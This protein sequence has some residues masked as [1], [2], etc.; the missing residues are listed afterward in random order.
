VA[1]QGL[2][3]GHD[4]LDPS[5]VHPACLFRLAERRDQIGM[6]ANPVELRLERRGAL[7][8]ERGSRNAGSRG[9]QHDPVARGSLR[10][11]APDRV[12]GALELSSCRG[13]VVDQEHDRTIDR[14]ALGRLEEDNGPPFASLD[15]FEV[16]EAEVGDGPI[17][18]IGGDDVDPHDV[19]FH[20]EDRSRMRRPA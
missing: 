10:Q 19:R 14:A 5:P 4:G 18:G 17:P 3:R 2:E 8:H 16:L 9:H 7:G 20:R 1:L 6:G 13:D 15:D 11:Q 12:P